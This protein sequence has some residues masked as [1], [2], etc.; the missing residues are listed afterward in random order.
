MAEEKQAWADQLADYR[1]E[2]QCEGL[3]SDFAGRTIFIL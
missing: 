2:N 1:P 3:Q